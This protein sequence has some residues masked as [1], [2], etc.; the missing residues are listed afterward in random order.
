MLQLANPIFLN[1][2]L[3]K[4]FI[5]EYPICSTQ[6]NIVVPYPTTDSDLYSYNYFPVALQQSLSQILQKTPH[7]NPETLQKHFID[8]L[9][10]KHQRS[11]LLFYQGGNHGSCV[12]VRQSLTSL[13]KGP[14][15]K[16]YFIVKGDKKREEGFLSAIFCPI[17]I[18]DSPS[19]KR[20]YDAIHVSRLSFAAVLV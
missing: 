15:T 4:L 19:S 6:K 1:V 12:K 11:K 18:G 7:T 2:E 9:T 10:S 14:T 8:Y 5:Q 13:T 17:P 16:E 20:M 3:S